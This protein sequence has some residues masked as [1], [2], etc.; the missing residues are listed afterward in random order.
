[1]ARRR[2]EIYGDQYSPLYVQIANDLRDRIIEGDIVTGEALPPERELCDLV[3]A[4]RVTVRKAIEQLIDEG[5]LQR[6]QG[7]G[8]FV[9]QRI[10]AAGSHLSSFTEDARARGD[11]V[12]TIWIRR[13]YG[14]ADDNEAALLAIEPGAKIAHLSRVRLSNDEPLA[15]EHAIIPAHMLP[16][17]K[18]LGPSLYQ[19]LEAEGNRPVSGTQKIRAARASAADALLLSISEGAEVLRIERVT[20]RADGQPVELT[21]SIYRGDRFEFVSE[22]SGA[23]TLA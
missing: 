2:V 3:G 4:S 5:L 17:I 7:S 19:A 23:V 15:V 11:N 16:P 12:D 18:T 21:R 20:R 8:T 10:Q 13:D 9:T 14:D 6:K 1:M 22:L